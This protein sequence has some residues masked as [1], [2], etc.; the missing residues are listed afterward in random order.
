MLS[1]VDHFPNSCVP[2][3]KLR[4]LRDR[5][6][7][8][9][10]RIEDKKNKPKASE[11][12]VVQEQK[13]A[14]KSTKT[15]LKERCAKEKASKESRKKKPKTIKLKGHSKIIRQNTSINRWEK[16]FAFLELTIPFLVSFS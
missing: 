16:D 8:L 7:K 11:V 10:K 3:E 14:K 1:L 2:I 12:A 6:K 5:E 15:S 13:K 4:K 9:R